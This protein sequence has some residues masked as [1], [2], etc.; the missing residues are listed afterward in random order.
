M[1]TF[2]VGLHQPAD[3]GKT[4]PNGQ[5]KVR[6]AC[7]SINRLRTRK[8][9]LKEPAEG[10]MMDSGAF[11]EIST[12]GKYR[13]AP[14]EYAR[15]AARWVTPKLKCIVAQDYM[16]EPFILKKTGLTVLEHQRLTIERYDALVIAWEAERIKA[17]AAN[18]NWPPVMPVLQGF[19]EEEYLRHIEMYGDR[20]KPGMWVGIGSVCKRQGDVKVIERLLIAIVAR[21]PDLLFHG[22]GV[23]LT[24]LRSLVVQIL[25]ETADSMAW[26]FSARKKG[27]NA[28]CVD[29]AVAFVAKVERMAA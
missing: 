12:H 26:S 7:V 2:F 11:T 1:R 21:R 27:R 18:D 25:L 6:F 16:C 9:P 10:W 17:G 19:T 15:E 20:L 5:P 22:F 13:H 24:A 28:N 23:K 4:H 8:A 3:C 14:E 29:E